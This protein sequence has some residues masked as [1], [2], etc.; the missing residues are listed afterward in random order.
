MKKRIAFFDFDGTITT[1]DTLLEF[2][3]FCKGSAGLYAGFLC[4]SPWIVAHKA[5]IISNQSAKEQVLRFFF[6]GD[7]L[8]SFDERCEAFSREALPRLIRPGALQEI[9]RLKSEGVT[10]VVVSASP[11]NWIRQWAAAQGV[12]LIASRL[13]VVDGRL[14]GRIAGRNCNGEEKV[15][16]ILE[17][18]TVKDYSEVYAYGDTGGDRPMLQ[19]ATQ[20]FY[21]PFRK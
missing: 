9:A 18:H 13:E 4:K 16:R 19:L 5:K 12:E 15:R 20:A 2:I 11:E 8:A 6:R 7:T 17:R 14:T 3:R 21:R 1:H 10:V